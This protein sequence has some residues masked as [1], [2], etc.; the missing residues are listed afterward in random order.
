MEQ[1]MDENVQ[2]DLAVACRRLAQQLNEDDE[3]LDTTSRSRRSK[4]KKEALQALWSVGDQRHFS[5]YVNIF[6]D[7][8]DKGLAG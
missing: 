2:H 1:E 8:L 4:E 3:G 6:S 5:L 7:P